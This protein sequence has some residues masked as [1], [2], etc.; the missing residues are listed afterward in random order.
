M[1]YL[2]TK[3]KVVDKLLRE[4]ELKGVV[5]VVWVS[6]VEAVPAVV[7]VEVLVEAVPAVAAI[8]AQAQ[9]ASVQVGRQCFLLC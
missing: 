4:W 3:V 7:G 8:V 9:S 1:S 5:A 6:V 2:L